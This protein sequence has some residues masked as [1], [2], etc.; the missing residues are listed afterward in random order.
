M[1]VLLPMTLFVP[2]LVIVALVGI[3]RIRYV[4]ISELLSELLYYCLSHFSFQG[5]I[6]CIRANIASITEN[7]D[8]YK[9][10]KGS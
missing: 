2:L 10:K 9:K 7:D 8:F 3:V 1:C 6:L 5:S 4:F